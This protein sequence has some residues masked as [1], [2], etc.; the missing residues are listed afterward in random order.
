MKK[1]VKPENPCQSV[2][3]T[4]YDIVRAHGG[5]IKVESVEN[6]GLPGKQ[7]GTESIIALP[8]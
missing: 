1:S 4:S 3:Q 5:E 7:T 8:T 6:Q 2:I